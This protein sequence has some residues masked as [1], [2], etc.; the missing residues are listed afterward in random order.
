MAKRPSDDEERRRRFD[1]FLESYGALLRRSI[2]N[3]C[4]RGRGLQL[5]DIE[6]DARLRVWR[7]VESATEITNPASYLYRVALSA[8]RDALR[9]VAARR[10]EPLRVRGAGGDDEEGGIDPPATGEE[11]SPERIAEGRITMRRIQ[12]ALAGLPDDSRR[13]V[14][15]HLR[16][17]TPPEIATLLAFSEPKTRSLVYRGLEKLRERLRK[18]GIGDD[19]R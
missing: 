7:A 18:E 2:V 10:E 1:S 3:V 8:T 16:G 15:L 11:S 9:R 13:A 19:D 4:P 14:G 5:D 17:F 6:Q 12:E